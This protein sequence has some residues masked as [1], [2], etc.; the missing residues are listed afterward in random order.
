[1][2]LK[3]VYNSCDTSFRSYDYLQTTNHVTN[4]IAKSGFKL[5]L[6]HH[7]F[8]REFAKERER[9]EH[10]RKFFKLRRQQQLDRMLTDYL[11][12]IST[13]EDIMLKE[14]REQHG[15]GEGQYFAI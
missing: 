7:F 3:N 12:W 2:R 14:E 6:V 13:A 15:V 5:I 9:V 8:F 10:R 1:M 11:D 4:R